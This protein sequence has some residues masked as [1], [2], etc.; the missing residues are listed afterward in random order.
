MAKLSDPLLRLGAGIMRRGPRGGS[1]AEESLYE[2]TLGTDKRRLYSC[3]INRMRWQG[4]A[5]LSPFR[6]APSADQNG[7][8]M[9]FCWGEAVL[10]VGAG[11]WLVN[12]SLQH[13]SAG[14]PNESADLMDL[15]H[16]PPTN[17]DWKYLLARC[18]K[19]SEVRG[20]SL[21]PLVPVPLARQATPD[22]KQSCELTPP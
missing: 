11:E 18:R 12:A 4:R 10:D 6:S 2:E 14:L 5:E 15:N 7:S 13:L 19:P 20:G 22:L 21:K 16:F 1:R 9:T 3:F 8:D 17:P